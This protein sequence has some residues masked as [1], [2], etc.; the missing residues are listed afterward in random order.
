MFKKDS[1]IKKFMNNII[2]FN[3]PA[4]QRK[5]FCNREI[6]VKPAL[7]PDEIIWE[8]LVFTGDDQKFRSIITTLISC[9]FL[10]FTTVFTIYIGTLQQ[11]IE[12]KIPEVNCP[13]Y[14]QPDDPNIFSYKKMAYKDFFRDEEL[15][16]GLMGCYC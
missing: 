14:F 16:E 11:F 13:V 7:E 12:T 4:V 3:T 5:L 10:I 1:G 8:N 15:Q 6:D 9:F 2:Y